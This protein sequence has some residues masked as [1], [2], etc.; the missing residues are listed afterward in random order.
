[1][2]N[3]YTLLS[4][5]T[6]VRFATSTAAHGRMGGSYAL[7]NLAWRNR[8]NFILKALKVDARFAVAAGLEHGNVIE[9]VRAEP[10]QSLCVEG[11]D[12]LLTTARD[13]PLIITHKDCVPIFIWG[14]GKEESLVGILHAGWRGVLQGRILPKAIRIA[15]DKHGV[16][17][18]S[19]CVFLGPAIQKCH[20]EVR[21]DVLK[22]F[23]RYYP[24]YVFERSG[25]CFVDL[26]RVLIAQ[27]RAAGVHHIKRSRECTYHTLNPKEGGRAY[28]SHRRETHERAGLVILGDRSF[29]ISVIVR[30]KK[31][32]RRGSD[33]ERRNNRSGMHQPGR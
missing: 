27:A 17:P 23:M 13:V 21:G 7:E 28:F 10:D 18:N 15:R 2:L 9:D 19:L 16:E 20:F 12:G 3:A 1:M 11:R 25:S 24:D 22:M 33:G 8:K 5:G 26:H 4:D 14:V 6:E 30:T 32:R 29:M 31:T